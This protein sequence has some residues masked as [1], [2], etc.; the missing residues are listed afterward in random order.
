MTHRTEKLQHLLR[1]EVGRAIKEELSQDDG[2]ILT[3]TRARISPTLEHATVYISVI[4]EAKEGLLL[5]FLNRHIYAVQRAINKRLVMRP[6]P[7]I[8]FEIDKAEEKAAEI[9]RLI[10]LANK[11]GAAQ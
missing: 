8:R 2:T 10:E 9:E 1:D 11:Q 5:A 6:V 3:V 4:P 7:K